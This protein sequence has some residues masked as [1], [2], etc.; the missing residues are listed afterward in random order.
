LYSK[1]GLLKFENT[2]SIPSP[3]LFSAQDFSYFITGYD[4]S[5]AAEQAFRTLWRTDCTYEGVPHQIDL[6]DGLVDCEAFAT[7]AAQRTDSQG[8]KSR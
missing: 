3:K 1:T 6:G 4:P 8:G 2:A 5:S 7:H